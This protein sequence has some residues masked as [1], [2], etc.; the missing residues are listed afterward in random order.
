MNFKLESLML[1]IKLCCKETTLNKET[2]PI[3]LC[4]KNVDRQFKIDFKFKT[5][6]SLKN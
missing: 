3:K 2:Q 4:K 5:K 6:F 1:N